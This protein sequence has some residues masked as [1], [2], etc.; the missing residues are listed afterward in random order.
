MR[1]LKFIGIGTGNP[2]HVT[3]AGLAAIRDA[4]CLLIPRKGKGKD[5]LAEI[6]Y[7][8][9]NRAD[10]RAKIV[11][12]EV[13]ERDADIPYAQAVDVWHDR[14]AEVWQKAIPQEAESVAFL[15]WGDP[16]LYD[17]SLRIAARLRPAPKTEIVP[18]ITAL[19]ALTAAHCI[20][21]NDINEPVLI[22]TGRQLRDNGWPQGAERIAVMLDGAC[23][24][25]GLDPTGLTIWWGAYLGLPNQILR[26]GPLL[27][28]GDDIVILRAEARAS[29]GWI[30]DTY[31]LAREKS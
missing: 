22:T 14:I 25:Q 17:S 10:P 4:D 3:L 30:M 23:A 6:R 20:P 8:I 19:Q 31:L 16:S 1:T 12:Y 27:E 24:F 29:H 18:G 15:I 21:L 11:E 5:D 7:D 28:V 2:A 9:V 13:P 26:S